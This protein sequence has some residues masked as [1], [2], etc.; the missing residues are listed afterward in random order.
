MPR[1]GPVWIVDAEHWPRAYLRAELI[2]RGH[3]AVGFATILDALTRLALRPAAP[4]VLVIDLGS[5]PPNPRQLDVL[6]RGGFSVLAIGGASAWASESVRARPW[7]GFLR[8]PLTVGAI[9][10]AVER[11][12]E[13]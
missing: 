6:L 8:R 3:D 2:E 13:R 10:D 9:A 12:L 5:Q 1:S 7:A 11:L 4:A